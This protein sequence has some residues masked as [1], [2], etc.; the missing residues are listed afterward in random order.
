LLTLNT[1][2]ISDTEGYVVYRGYSSL[3]GVMA[4]VLHLGLLVP[5][6]AAGLVLSWPQR[7]EIW[8]LHVILLVLLASIVAFYV[9][10]RYRFPLVP[11]LAMF[12]AAGVVE[13]WRRR[14]DRRQLVGAAM[15]MIA[16]A[17]VCNLPVNPA[18]QLDASA[19]G[20]LA[21][22][23]AEQGDLVAAGNVLDLALETSPQ[24]A[25]LHYNRAVAYRLAGDPRAALDQL[26]EAL[27]LQPALPQAAR[28]MG[29]AHEALGDRAAAKAWF[30]RALRENPNDPEARAGAGRTAE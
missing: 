5:L 14:R 18:A 12:A 4:T 7:R 28:E 2:E 8:L 27:R 23:L 22:V 20:N 29:L 10:A 26:A 9:L 16:T 17:V 19:Y 21:T 25:V 15:A 6:A 11:V 3:L 24:S 1:Y 30:I 13:A